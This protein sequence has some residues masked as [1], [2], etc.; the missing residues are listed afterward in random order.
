[1]TDTLAEARSGGPGHTG[2]DEAFERHRGVLL[3]L[4]YRMLG[5][6][7]DAEDVVQ[8]A[9]LRWQRS[10]PASIEDPRGWL[11]TATTR[12]ALDQLRSARRRRETYV[13]PWVPEPVPTG[14][15][16][17]DPAETAEQRATL[18]LAAL[19]LMEQLSPPE[20]AVY[21]LREAFEL[22]Y[23]DIADTLAISAANARQLYHR[24]AA[25][26][27]G[28]R[29]RFSV[30]R[31][32]HLDLVDRFVAAAATGDRAGLEALLARDVVLWNDGGGRISASRNPILGPEK[33]VRFLLGIMRRHA[34]TEAYRIDVNGAPAVLLDFGYRRVLLAFETADDGIVGV[35][36]LTNPDKLRGIGAPSDDPV[37]T[38]GEAAFPADGGP[39]GR[40]PH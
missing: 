24:A 6:W 12:L 35:Q 28:D 29:T 14:R 37:F 40:A 19:R 32:E 9:W 36:G 39:N 3:G 33:V 30:D 15:L 2:A 8:E 23:Q 27:G 5:S 1:M 20:R 34:R 4:A 10:D 18:S 13:G 26:I 17:L 16:A 31:R 11:V 7:F 21:L 38:L 25:R 22:P